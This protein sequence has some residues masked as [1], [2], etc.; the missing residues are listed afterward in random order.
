MTGERGSEWRSKGWITASLFVHSPFWVSADSVT[1]ERTKVQ[2]VLANMGEYAVLLGV[3]NAAVTIRGGYVAIKHTRVT[4]NPLHQD[5]LSVLVLR[6]NDSQRSPLRGGGAR[7]IPKS[8]IFGCGGCP[9]DVERHLAC[10]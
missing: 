4:P 6:L 10:R 1:V 3:G 5:G 9:R 7:L 8:C 2:V